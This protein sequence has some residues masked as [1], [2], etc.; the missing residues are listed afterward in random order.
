[1]PSH[2]SVARQSGVRSVAMKSL[3]SGTNGTLA[4]VPFVPEI[5]L[6]MATD[7]TPLWRATEAWLGMHGLA[8]PF[9]CVPWAGGQALARWVLD[10]PEVVRGRRVVDFGT[11]SG[12]VAIAC[13]LA[14]A[15]SVRAIDV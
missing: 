10:H 3:I 1:M 12:L 8:V 15:R 5:R 14:G 13:A 7:L 4:S 6:F 11:G 9:W 2:A